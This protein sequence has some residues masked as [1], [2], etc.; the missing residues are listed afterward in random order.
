VLNFF[1]KNFTLKIAYF[2]L[3]KSD[4]S[5]FPTERLRLICLACLVLVLIIALVLLCRPRKSA[6]KAVPTQTC[7]L[8]A[9][10]G[11]TDAGE[12]I[13][14]IKEGA[15]K[16][17]FKSSVFKSTSKDIGCVAQLL[18]HDPALRRAFAGNN[19]L[20]AY[21]LLPADSLHGLFILETE[22]D[23]YI[24][25]ILSNNIL[26][27]QISL[28]KFASTPL[29]AV[30]SSKH[31]RVFIAQK[32]HLLLFSHFS[33]LVED[34]LLQLNGSENGWI[35]HKQLERFHPEAGLRV[36]VHP[37]KWLEHGEGQLKDAARALS[38]RFTANVD[39]MGVAWN[40]TTTAAMAETKGFLSQMG[41][42]EGSRRG[43]IFSVIPDNTAFF[44]WAGFNNKRRFLDA[45]SHEN[46]ADFK[47]YI[48]PWIGREVAL[49][50]TDPH[51][52][53]L[54][55][56]RLLLISVADSTLSRQL[57][58]SYAQLRGY[59]AHDQI[60]MFEVL[61]VQDNSLLTPFFN[62]LDKDFQ[63]P[64][65]THLGKYVIVASNRQSIEKYIE[66]Y[67]ENQ[68]LEQN[69]DLLQLMQKTSEKGCGMLVM[70]T[71]YLH[72]LLQQM[73]VV[74]PSEKAIASDVEAFSSLGW[75]AVDLISETGQPS[76]LLVLSQPQSQPPPPS[77]I[78]WKTNLGAAVSSG[79]VAIQH[80]D[81]R[82]FQALLVQDAQT[83]L[84]CLKPDGTIVWQ[85]YIG[86]PI[87]SSISPVD[88][89]N[90]GRNC[91]LFNTATQVWL[92]DEHGKD[93]QGYP[94]DISAPLMGGMTVV[95]FDKNK[96]F[97]YFLCST[98]GQVY[99]FD[100][101]GR[102]LEGWNPQTNIGVAVGPLL[103]F[104]QDQKDFLVLL[105]RKGKLTVLGRDGT[106]RFKALDLEGPFSTAP[107][108]VV[109]CGKT[110][111]VCFN[112]TGKV[113]ICNL[114]GRIQSMKWSGGAENVPF[115]VSPWKTERRPT[116]AVLQNKKIHILRLQE[117]GIKTG[118]LKEFEIQQDELFPLDGGMGLYSKKSRKITRID[119]YG[120]VTTGFPLAGDGRCCL[121]W[122][123]SKKA[124][125]CGLGN[126]IYAYTIP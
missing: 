70:N 114:E 63:N 103:H 32:G 98:R 28:N 72:E 122:E 71:R 7:L 39:W 106:P 100:Q 66:K 119:A 97:N 18:H 29:Y 93:I 3:K 35:E 110:Q 50:V 19:L 37:Q 2:A 21:S 121:F 41:A 43:D 109:F 123:N 74:V 75:L 83:Q 10:H 52:P 99:G 59:Q 46:N 26:N 84:Y 101:Y 1:L 117:T 33:Y 58:Q 13:R 81:Q 78:F 44:A 126:T 54:Q 31:E 25:K 115:K 64:Y 85:K 65:L 40:G 8:L 57:L 102:P 34:A 113:Y 105:S 5:I 53:G 111:I 87:Q 76:K 6:F 82:T 60:G 94:L 124:I 104:Q 45:L 73:L 14:Q 86:D 79:V 56:D 4:M 67:I 108:V 24:H 90:N 16:D 49:V 27:I 9:F 48:L 116:F 51:S 11:L 62:D 38:Q 36:F 80:P 42:W 107:F 30:Q 15:W 125:A 55:D 88:Y 12:Q 118:V 112:D 91:Y 17:V 95:D 77:N 20:A 120:R 47:Q 92:M 61:G 68:T 23:V 69:T 22:N 89:F 96:K